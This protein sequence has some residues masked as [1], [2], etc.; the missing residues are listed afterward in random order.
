MRQTSL[1]F[2]TSEVFFFATGFSVLSIAKQNKGRLLDMAGQRGFFSWWFGE[3]REIFSGRPVPVHA[4]ALSD[5]EVALL[6]K[7]VDTPIGVVD[8]DTED[9]R[10]QIEGLRSRILRRRGK[11]PIVEVQLPSEQVMFAKVALPPDEDRREAVVSQLQDLTGQAPENL[12]FDVAS[13][14]DAEGRTVVAIAPSTS[15]EEASRYAQEWGFEPVRVT[16]IETPKAFRRGPDLDNQRTSRV[17]GSILPKLAVAL[18]VMA[19]CLSSA[20]A[21]R[22]LSVRTDLAAEAKAAAATVK[23]VSGDLEERQLAL[24]EFASAAATATDFR[25]VTMPVWRILAEAASTIPSDVVLTGFDYK[26]GQIVLRGSTKSTVALEEA[27][28]QSPIF[29]APTLAST[30]KHRR[31]RCLLYTSDAATKA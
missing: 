16:S 23:P 14:L 31:G 4:L 15:V 18:G 22:A 25:D 27:L 11:N 10:E 8:I 2:D 26:A 20:A 6:E 9:W 19:V 21:V 30:S 7:G 17:A 28:D 5:R 12:A 13:K 1:D 29:N 3:L 24:A